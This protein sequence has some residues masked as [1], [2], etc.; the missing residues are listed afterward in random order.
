MASTRRLEDWETDFLRLAY[1]T[2][3]ASSIGAVLGR[4][5]GAVQYYAGRLGLRK[6]EKISPGDQFG[7]LVVLDRLQEKRHRCFVWRCRCRCGAETTVKSNTLLSGYTESCGCKRREFKQ[8]GTQSICG[9]L[10]GSIR[11]GASARGIRFDLSNDFLEALF[12]K[13]HGRCALS[14]LL[15]EAKDK[16]L[17][18]ASLDRIRSER[19]Y[20]E[21]NVQWVHKDVNYMKMDF[22]QSYFLEVC[23]R[24][25]G[26]SRS[27]RCQSRLAV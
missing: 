22:D 3:S 26:H 24:I 15:L 17:L 2:E 7:R 23:G 5:R 18:T 21:D 20:V 8:T 10:L 1:P 11:R 4:S 19:P 12:Q 27:K 13:Q 25:A 16:H 9:T 14:G 6:P